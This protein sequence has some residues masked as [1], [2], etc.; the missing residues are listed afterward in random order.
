MN[1]R[2]LLTAATA[3]FFSLALA[4]NAADEPKK[5]GP[6]FDEMDT[7]KDGKVSKKEYMEANKNN[8]KAGDRFAAL[9][10]NKDD[11]LTKEEMQAGSKKKKQ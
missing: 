10:T 11:H 5:K 6:S 3:A 2:T 4:L 7:N 9:D 1:K 8:A